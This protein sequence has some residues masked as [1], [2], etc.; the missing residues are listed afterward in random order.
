MSGVAGPSHREVG[1][2]T[3]AARA[4]R[5]QKREKAGILR[6]VGFRELS[7]GECEIAKFPGFV[8]SRAFERARDFFGHD[9]RVVERNGDVSEKEEP[10]TRRG[11]DAF[12]SLTEG[13]R[14]ECRRYE[15]RD[16]SRSW[17]VISIPEH[18]IVLAVVE[19]STDAPIP[20]PIQRELLREVTGV[21][22]YEPEA[23]A[24]AKH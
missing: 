10:L 19:G 15:F 16:G 17:S 21:K 24:R 3:V 4:L 1:E 5:F 8:E 22:K 18:E 9:A 7:V 6:R 23:L 2:R 12:W 14:L 20:E 13:R 11:F